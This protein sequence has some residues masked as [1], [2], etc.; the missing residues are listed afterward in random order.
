MT[1]VKRQ[2][3]ANPREAWA[4]TLLNHTMLL[5]GAVRTSSGKDLD[6]VSSRLAMLGVSR[7]PVVLQDDGTAVRDWWL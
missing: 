7:M 5:L 1:S 2:A 6:C 3:S 4:W